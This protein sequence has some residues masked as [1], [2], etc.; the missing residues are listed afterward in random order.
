MKEF[1]W[2]YMSHSTHSKSKLSKQALRTIQQNTYVQ[3]L[4]ARSKL[5]NWLIIKQWLS[6]DYI[7]H[8]SDFSIPYTHSLGI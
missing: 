2:Y 6:L 5:V 4:G 3:S 1:Y 8:E 7:V